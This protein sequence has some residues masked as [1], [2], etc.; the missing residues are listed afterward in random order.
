MNPSDAA[1]LGI[2]QNRPV[3]VSNGS[4][5]LTLS[6]A[7]TDAVAAGSVFLPLLYDGGRVN[8]LLP[9]DGAPATVTVR[10]A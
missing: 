9:A 10:P 4:H 8:Q 2:A 5:E 6:A 3:L 7:L 1:A